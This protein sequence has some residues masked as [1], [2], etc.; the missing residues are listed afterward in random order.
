MELTVHLHRFAGKR[1]DDL[2][3]VEILLTVRI[4]L[5][6]FSGTMAQ[7]LVVCHLNFE[8]GRLPCPV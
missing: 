3:G 4:L 1:V 5:E 6:Q 2:V 8:S 7:E